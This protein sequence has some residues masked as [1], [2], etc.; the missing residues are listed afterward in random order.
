[1]INILKIS[2]VGSDYNQLRMSRIQEKAMLDYSSLQ[3]YS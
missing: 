3:F 1:M 2:S